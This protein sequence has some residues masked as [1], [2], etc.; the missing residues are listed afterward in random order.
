MNSSVWGDIRDVFSSDGWTLMTQA[1]RVVQVEPV[2]WWGEHLVCFWRPG[3]SL[4]KEG[5]V[6]LRFQGLWRRSSDTKGDQSIPINQAPINLNEKAWRWETNSAWL[7][8]FDH[9]SSSKRHFLETTLNGPDKTSARHKVVPKAINRCWAVC[10]R[11][12]SQAKSH[13]GWA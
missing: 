7:T 1:P 8:N 12:S 11:R 5:W 10:M 4:W 9:Q 13:G 2:S 6:V 3:R